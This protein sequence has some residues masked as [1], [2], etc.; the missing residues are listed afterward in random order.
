MAVFINF[1][2]NRVR[3]GFFLR[4]VASKLMGEIGFTGFAVAFV[5]FD[6][7]SILTMTWLGIPSAHR[8][9][10]NTILIVLAMAVFGGKCTGQIANTF[11]KS[12]SLNNSGN[13]SQSTPNSL[14]DVLLTSTNNGLGLIGENVFMR[15]VVVQNG[16]HYAISNMS[17]NSSRAITLGNVTPFNN[18]HTGGLNDVIALSGN[19]SLS[20]IGANT[21]GGGPLSA[22]LG[23]HGNFL[24]QA[25]STLSIS[26]VIS[27]V[28]LGFNKTGAGLMTLSGSNTYSGATN[29][30]GGT[31]AITN[32]L[33]L[34]SLGTIGF[35]GGTLRYSGANV[36]LSNRFSVDSNQHIS[37]DTNGHD[38]TFASNLI[39][40]GGS[41]AKSG[42]GKL[43]LSG[44]NTYSGTT[45]INSGVLIVNGTQ[46]G[47]EY[48]INSSGTL[49]GNGIIKATV[50]VGVGGAL[51]S[52][53]GLGTLE[54]G[55]NLS[56][57]SG[58]TLAVEINSSTLQ[59]D[60]TRVAGSLALNNAA[61]QLT[62]FANVLIPLGT[63]VTIATFN[64]INGEFQGLGEGARFFNGQNEWKIS[65]GIVSAG[66]ITLTAVP[67]P[68]S[69]LF[70]CSAL[71]LSST[72]RQRR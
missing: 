4:R 36:D 24:V 32:N 71:C 19:S 22:A 38:I 20:I 61:L 21:V 26:S 16:G 17:S 51:A 35:G 50:H 44:T 13:F 65:Y 11:Y 58:S 6:S 14:H 66:K 8:T 45:T 43:V 59:S 15:S 60:L 55:G 48:F 12:F 53:D 34:G 56:F 47:G 29:I 25:G 9:I 62:D 70:V 52:G 67:E 46:T 63:E 33:A 7:R 41:L 64:S 31:L 18:L 37:I 30:N 49:A 42:A 40:V 69:L 72:R 28:N 39:S 57:V 2:K 27:G 10:L 54:I 68:T 3:S 5:H 23:S 1:W